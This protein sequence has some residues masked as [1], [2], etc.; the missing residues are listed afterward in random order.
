MNGVPT[1]VDRLALSRERLR[2]A[3]RVSSVSQQRNPLALVVGAVVLVGL[4]ARMRSWRWVPKSVL[5][6]GLLPKIVLQTVAR[7]PPRLWMNVLASL[8]QKWHGPVAS[9]PA[10]RANVS[11]A[12]VS[13][14]AVRKM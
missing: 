9:P 3:L 4:V 11:P 1:A 5:F 14:P 10:T 7:L 13:V 2:Q 8:I 12:P 6:A